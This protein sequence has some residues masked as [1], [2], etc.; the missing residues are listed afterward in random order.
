MKSLYRGKRVAAVLL[1]LAYMFTLCLQGDWNVTLRAAALEEYNV[2]MS[3]NISEDYLQNTTIQNPVKA[4][5]YK[6][7]EV[8]ATVQLTFPS[9]KT[10]SGN[11]FLLEEAGLYSI[12]VAA[13]Y[14][15]TTYT[16]AKT[17]VVHSP[18]FAVTEGGT[19]EYRNHP[20]T[21]ITGIEASISNLQGWLV[22]IPQGGK[23]TVQ[24]PLNLNQCNLEKEI[25]KLYVVSAEKGT[26]DFTKIRFT[27]T[28]LADPD[29]YVV[30]AGRNTQNG[31]NP[32][33]HLSYW[34]AGASDQ[35]LVGYQNDLGQDRV[36]INSNWGMATIGSFWMM[37]YCGSSTEDQALV[38]DSL[39]L[40][41]DME[42]RGI[43]AG[44]WPRLICDLD[45]PRYHTNLW[46]GFTSG[47]C[48][49]T[50]ECDLYTGTNP[51]Q[52]FIT[53]LLGVD[54]TKNA[55][56]D[57]T[58]PTVEV[59]FAGYDE[60]NLPKACVGKPYP[61]FEA[62]AKDAEQNPSVVDVKV[63]GGM[64]SSSR[65]SLDVTDG[66][67]TPDLPGTYTIVYT[68]TDSWGNS[69]ER[70]VYVHAGAEQNDL[71]I[72]LDDPVKAGVVAEKILLPGYTVT[73]NYGLTDVEIFV[74]ADGKAIK[75][76]TQDFTPYAAGT[77]R[78]VYS[79]RDYIRQ[80]HTVE[81]E[82]QVAATTKPVFK[83]TPTLNRYMVSG[84]VNLIPAAT[85]YNYVTENGTP[86]DA[87]SFVRDK[88]GVHT[89][90][91]TTFTP[92]D[93]T[94][95]CQVWWEAEING[96]R[97]KTEEITVPVVSVKDG[98][99]YHMER[100]FVCQDATASANDEYISV[101]PQRDG[102]SAMWSIPVLA[103]G[104]GIRLTAL[105][106]KTLTVLM[107]DSLN[108]QQRLEIV[109]DTKTARA[110]ING[111]MTYQLT[112][113]NNDFYL[114]YDPVSKQV[115][116]GTV[117][118]APVDAQG[119][120]FFGFDSGKIYTSISFD[121]LNKNAEARIRSLNSQNLNN[122]T[123][124]VLKPGVSVMGETGGFYTFGDQMT[125]HK[126][127]AADVLSP[128]CTF[129]LSVFDPNGEI[130]MDVNGLLLD[131]VS[132]DCIYTIESTMIG[133]YI[134]Q[135]YAED[136]EGNKERNII[137][138]LTVIDCVAPAI[139]V[140]GKVPE[141]AKIGTSITIPSATAQDDLDGELQM[142]IYVQHPDLRVQSITA[143]DFEVTS[144]GMYVVK[145]YAFDLEGNA[146]T[147]EYTVFVE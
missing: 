31:P 103:E 138:P 77:Y 101:Y 143:G 24:V 50:I 98:Q 25:I 90:E 112:L 68:A 110:C 61:I 75:Q 47:I 10:A 96:Q 91:G 145:Y 17:F 53:E 5:T 116:D 83:D 86:I 128:Y 66:T 64:N 56:Y 62:V 80:E 73:G 126:S 11:T 124:D 58:A 125:V 70:L 81:Y 113:Q 123:F 41:L 33:E 105:N 104:F 79:V 49:L 120:P 106:T 2:V 114:T 48:Q 23:L 127:I 140:D 100:Y 38:E 134:V 102:A 78:V 43:Y 146:T 12:K 119:N 84:M 69:G 30:A 94:T 131:R 32:R 71:K 26:K 55:F 59:D 52:I 22:T 36:W 37:P 28:D 99:N 135:F 19:I 40:W 27:L 13:Q 21:E 92:A 6:G 60:L 109:I 121:G 147:L 130:A 42:E 20:Y 118:I 115:S 16:E 132:P 136:S 54:L 15:G 117:Y 34:Q 65:Y 3:W 129:Y 72:Q 51:A 35:N 9:G 89:V 85:A 29:N 93:G 63:Y 111:G 8:S 46:E 7:A 4:M 133:N 44:R 142:Y 137:Y 45:E 107:E 87:E 141:S 95:Q 18:L 97:V 67:F 88:N 144:A 108:E 14:E 39:S 57:K 1:L 139:Q 122:R 74:S 82:V 76:G